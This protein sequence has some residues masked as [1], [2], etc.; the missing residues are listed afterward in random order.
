MSITSALNTAMSGLRAAG[1]ASEVVSSNISNVA[2]PGY[3]RRTLS[4]TSAAGGF[5]GGVQVNGIVRHVDSQV[6]SDRRL[7]GAEFGYRSETSGF[8]NSI[9]D[10]LGTPDQPG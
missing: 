9:E 4:T 6:L 8:L 1:R 7:A 3:A 10:L 5:T 2:T